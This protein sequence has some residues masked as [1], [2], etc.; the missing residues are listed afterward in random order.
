MLLL[1]D[2]LN[3]YRDRPV[4]GGHIPSTVWWVIVFLGLFDRRPYR[5]LGMRSLWVHFMLLA[6]ITTGMVIMVTPIAQLDYPFRGE[7]S[8][9]TEPLEHLLSELGP[10][11]GPNSSTGAVP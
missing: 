4:A 3:A 10:Q 1:N 9:S 6:A 11:P 8:V 7:V 5:I 2:L